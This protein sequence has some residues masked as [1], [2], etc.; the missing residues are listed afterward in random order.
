MRGFNQ[1][2]LLSRS[3]SQSI[4]MICDIQDKFRPVIYRFPAIVYSTSR[5]LRGCND[6]GIPAIATEQYPKALGSTIDE[7]RSH[8]KP[9]DLVVPKT[10]FSM[11]APDVENAL[12]QHKE[13]TQVLLC[14]LETHVCVL[15]TTLDLLERGYEVHLITDALSS[16]RAADRS[17]ALQ[18]MSQAGAF[19][20]TSEMALFQL[21]RDAKHPKFKGISALAKEA[22]EEQLGL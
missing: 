12:Q 16:Q 20:S 18:R 21:A 2:L 10:L 14:G 17:V 4:L 1:P 3:I 11:L 9:T 8:L 5:V 19:L 6:L 15:Q 13:R 22:R 7:L